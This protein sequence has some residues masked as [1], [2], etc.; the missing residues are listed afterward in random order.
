MPKLFCIV[1]GHV[2]SPF[3]VDVAADETVGDLKKKIMVE[4]KSI[5]CDADEL[6][7]YLVDGLAQTGKTRFDFKGTVIDDMPARLLSDFDGS[8]SEMIETFPLSSYSRRNDSSVGRIHVLVVVP[9]GAVRTLSL[10]VFWVVNG[11][12]ENAL[13]V[14][15]VRSRL[16]RLAHLNLAYYDPNHADAFAYDHKKLMVHI[17]FKSGKLF[18]ESSFLL[19]FM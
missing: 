12:V 10:N 13:D 14:K 2:G 8:T 3:P 9:E 11:Y 5:A 6:E 7:I 1:V 19:T 4:K 16:Y 18:A 17:L 15:G